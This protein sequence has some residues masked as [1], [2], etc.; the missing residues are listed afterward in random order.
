MLLND[1]LLN[2][3]NKHLRKCGYEIMRSIKG[4]SNTKDTTIHDFILKKELEGKPP[5]V[6]KIAGLNKFLRIY[7]AKVRESLKIK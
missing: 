4:H 3:G 5:K 1:I 2:D 7:Y 6:C